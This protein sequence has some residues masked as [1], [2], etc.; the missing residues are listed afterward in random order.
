MDANVASYLPSTTDENRITDFELHWNSRY[1][2]MAMEDWLKY[3]H[4]ENKRGIEHISCFSEIAV[5]TASIAEI[6]S[7]WCR[8][9]QLPHA[10]LYRTLEIYDNFIATYSKDLY[11]N[12]KNSKQSSSLQGRA[13]WQE[14]FTEIKHQ[15][16]LYLV[17]CFQIA[18][19]LEL[20]YKIITVNRAATLLSQA[21]RPCNRST[22]LQAEIQVLVTL[23]YDVN[24]PPVIDYAETLICHLLLM[25]KRQTDQSTN[26]LPTYIDE[27]HSVVKMLLLIV[28]ID[29][30][31]LLPRIVS[32]L[33]G[34][35]VQPDSKTYQKYLRKVQL[36]K[37]L[38]AAASICAA[39]FLVQPSIA[40]SVMKDIH[41][42][43]NIHPSDTAIISA[44]IISHLDPNSE[45]VS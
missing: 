36:N 2:D 42:S 12:W 6:V 18:S 43:V 38:M 28:H 19:K 7:V 44:I 30:K 41:L 11:I 22:I 4:Q 10:V 31:E 14:I 3:L 34:S 5:F 20:S 25:A 15:G 39:S 27:L 13:H 23:K 33:Y 29:R 40:S 26:P 16:L 9:Y 32:G 24:Y 17:S 8:N 35:D 21:H 1:L 45:N 37:M